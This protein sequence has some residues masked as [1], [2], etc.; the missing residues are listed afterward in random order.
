[1]SDDKPRAVEPSSSA[2]RL[3][4]EIRSQI[5][6]GELV[7]GTKVTEADLA[8]RF[9]VNRAPLREALLR[10]EERRLIDRVPFS[11]TRIFQPSD[12]MMSDLFDIR[13]VMEGLACRRAA[14]LITDAEIEELERENEAAAQRLAAEIESAP[15]GSKPIRDLH[16]RIAQISGNVELQRFLN[17]EVWH[18][19]RASYRRLNKSL[20]L[21]KI[22][23]RHHE[24][25][26]EALRARQGE[27]AEQLMRQH[28]RFNKQTW[29]ELRDKSDDTGWAVREDG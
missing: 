23:A 7:P 24:W 15:S 19:M 16:V 27:M 10:L 25:I 18:Y 2:N 21:R 13:E 17:G 29:Q 5:L 9:N 22:G 4:E 8:Q 11:G 28:I 6:D 26:V 14:E 3:F 12:K 1:M 20:K